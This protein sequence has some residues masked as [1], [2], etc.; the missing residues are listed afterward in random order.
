[1][2]RLYIL[3]LVY[4]KK[5]TFIA[6]LANTS[7]FLFLL[8]KMCSNVQIHIPKRHSRLSIPLKING[9]NHTLLK[10]SLITRI[11]SSLEHPAQSQRFRSI[12]LLILN[13]IFCTFTPTGNTRSCIEYQEHWIIFRTCI[14]LLA[15]R[16]LAAVISRLQYSIWQCGYKYNAFTSCLVLGS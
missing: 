15:I 8:Y 4:P 9:E 6:K 2:A 16:Y 11:L 3:P 10:S 7:T 12:R 5:H 1:M 14:L 13:R